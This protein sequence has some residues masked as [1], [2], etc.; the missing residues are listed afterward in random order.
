MICVCGKTKLDGIRCKFGATHKS[1]EQS[2]REF[3]AMNPHVGE[4]KKIERVRLNDDPPL[5]RERLR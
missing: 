1:L 2:K 4:P 5:F 3:R